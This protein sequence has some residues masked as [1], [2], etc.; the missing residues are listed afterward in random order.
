MIGIILSYLLCMACMFVMGVE[1]I[2]FFVKLTPDQE[3]LI[4]LIALP[5]API[6]LVIAIF[7][8]IFLILLKSAFHFVGSSKELFHDTK[9]YI[10]SCK[11]GW[12][13]FTSKEIN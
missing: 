10:A 7:A 13:S 4:K 9:E 8:I 6:V 1:L 2:S 5:F 12:K 11:R 3:N